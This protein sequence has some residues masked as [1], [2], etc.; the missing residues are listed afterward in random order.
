M[1]SQTRLSPLKVTGTFCGYWE[2][3]HSQLII[4]MDDNMRTH[5][6]R[7]LPSIV[8]GQEHKDP[9]DLLVAK[10]G[11]VGRYRIHDYGSFFA[12]R[13]QEKAFFANFWCKKVTIVLNDLDK[14]IS[15]KEAEV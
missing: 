15:I 4:L 3:G 1:K 12:S 5:D 13:E 6:Y 10:N 11:Q 9:M 14:V 8:V 2:D 7:I